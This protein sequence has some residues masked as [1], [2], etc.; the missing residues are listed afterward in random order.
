MAEAAS[1]APDLNRAKRVWSLLLTLR[2]TT[3]RWGRKTMA[4]LPHRPQLCVGSPRH[5]IVQAWLDWF[6]GMY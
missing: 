1:R 5:W 6:R 3:P 2:S 4:F